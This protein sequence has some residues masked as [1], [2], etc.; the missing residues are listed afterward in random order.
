LSIDRCWEVGED[1]YDVSAACFG[2]KSSDPAWA[3]TERHEGRD[4]SLILGDVLGAY[5]GR[6]TASAWDRKPQVKSTAKWVE[7]LQTY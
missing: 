7:R 4:A 3:I 5:V 1:V 6:F 2:S